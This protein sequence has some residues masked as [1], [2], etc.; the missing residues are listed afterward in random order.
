M[1]LG[2]ASA[3]VSFSFIAPARRLDL[4]SALLGESRGMR[5]CSFNE[6]ENTSFNGVY[7]F[8][9]GLYP[10]NGGFNGKILY[11]I[12]RVFSWGNPSYKC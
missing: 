3:P 7:I 4:G 1:A 11:K 5:G 9:F 12:N 6:S 8:F 2:H 10:I